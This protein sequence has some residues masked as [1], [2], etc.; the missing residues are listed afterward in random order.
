M[1]VFAA[2]TALLLLATGSAPRAAAQ[3]APEF[4]ALGPAIG[5]LYR[6]DGGPAPHVGV[7][8]MHRTA[9]FLTHPACHGL[10]ARGFARLCMNS[11]FANNEIQVDWDR[12]TLDV[13][14]G[15]E[16][17]RRQRGITRVVLFGHSGGGPTMSFYQ[18]VAEGGVTYCQNLQ[19]IH[20]CAGD[21]AGLPPADGLILADAH[22]G[23]PVMV[24]RALLPGVGPQNPPVRALSPAFDPF[25]TA[26]GYNPDCSSRYAPDFQRRWFEGQAQRMAAS[27]RDA[28]ER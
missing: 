7:L 23:Q 26:N 2:V 27:T 14:A 10:S 3:G 18:A 5:A 13:R 28:A 8:F 9:N 24:M 16:A 6:P 22:P 20:P 1:R 11:R 19:R 21:L 17:L 15:V 12:I 25:S 4:L